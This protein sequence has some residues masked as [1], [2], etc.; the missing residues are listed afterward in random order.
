MP[1]WLSRSS[2]FSSG[3]DPR[4]LG[5]SPM[6]GSLLS[7]ESASPSPI[8]PPLTLSFSCSFF[9]SQINKIFKKQNKTLSL[10]LKQQWEAWL[11]QSLK[12]PTLGFQLRSWSQG[13]GIKSHVGLHAQIKVCLRFSP[14]PSVPLPAHAHV[15]TL[16]LS[17]IE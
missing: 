1:G 5:L 15:C 9:L 13:H 2:A 3:H 14:F 12:H 6:L 7:G 16:S 4:V 8:A 11:A 10:Y 17:Q